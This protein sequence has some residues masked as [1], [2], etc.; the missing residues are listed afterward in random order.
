MSAV[1][2]KTTDALDYAQLIQQ[3]YDSTTSVVGQLKA[4]RRLAV[5]LAQQKL[6]AL[7]KAHHSW[8]A[9]IA[10]NTG[11]GKTMMAQLMCRAC[12][13][14]FSAADATKFSETGFAGRDLPTMFLPLIEDA[15]AVYDRQL[16]RSAFRTVPHRKERYTL[17]RPAEELEPILAM[18]QTGV[19]LL[20]EFD[21]WMSRK[22]TQG[23]D[24][25][26]VLQGELL[27][28]ISGT[29]EWIIQSDAED[30]PGVWF[31]TSKVLIICCGA[32]VGLSERVQK[33]LA[34]E[35]LTQQDQG[36]WDLVEPYDFQSFGVIPELAGRQAV[37]ILLRALSP[38]DLAVII[39]RPGG[40]VDEFAGYFRAVGGD[41][42]LTEGDLI[43]LASAAAE[44]DTGARSL[45]FTFW[46][47][48]GEALYE[49]T[50]RHGG[51]AHLDESGGRAYLA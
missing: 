10:G 45:D 31:D 33:R 5:L 9:V 38:K 26:R 34:R 27:A 6:V 1:S 37:H 16:Q 25:G 24:V 7:G 44:L 40:I 48:F 47:V 35:Q 20:D 29:R 19:V 39:K 50:Q 36:F 32:F 51:V 4:R 3:L 18:A 12:E 49:A 15:S 30:A 41:L 28:M 8:G 2:L 42:E 14:P 43:R 17:A 21:K 23:R 11:V 13:L 46:S 22:D